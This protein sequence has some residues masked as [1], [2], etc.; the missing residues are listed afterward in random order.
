M[1]RYLYRIPIG[2]NSVCGPIALSV[3][4]IVT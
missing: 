2:E 4:Y 1:K 3:T